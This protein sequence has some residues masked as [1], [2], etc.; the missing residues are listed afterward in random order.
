VAVTLRPSTPRDIAFI[1]ALERDAVNR[2]LIG[3]WSDWEHLSAIDGRNGREHW[4][5]ERDGKPA[6]YLIAYD[7]RAKDAGIYVKRILVDDKEKGTG[8]EALRQFIAKAAARD[9]VSCV[10]LVVRRGNERA[11]HVYAKLGFQRFEPSPE[12]RARYDEYESPPD[13]MAFRMRLPQT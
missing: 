12:E 1:T 11:Q 13:E 6:G 9:R 8:S 3:Q 4:L 5:I 2:E 7:C 10:W